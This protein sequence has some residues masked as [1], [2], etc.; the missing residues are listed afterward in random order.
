MGKYF[1]IIFIVMMLASSFT[2][3]GSQRTN[4]QIE[5]T[6]EEYAVYSALIDSMFTGGR[7]TFDT[8]DQ[9]KLLVI[10][11][12]TVDSSLRA[13]HMEEQNWKELKLVFP[14][15]LQ[16]AL[17]DFA[18]KNKELQPLKDKFNIKLKRTL[19]KK[20]ELEQIFS[21]S[22]NGWNG[23]Y[24]KFPDSGGYIGV[25]RVGFDVRKKQALVYFEHNCYR[26]CASGHFVLLKMSEAGWKVVKRSMSWIS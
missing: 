8:K 2:V 26:L 24:N 9:V 16:T 17:A 10:K 11:D 14:M 12:V 18:A 21:E 1:T 22:G 6:D 15:L 5:I 23:F 20:D 4:R 19:I 7:V 3:F 25:S 13:S